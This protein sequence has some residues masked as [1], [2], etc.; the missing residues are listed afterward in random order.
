MVSAVCT[1]NVSESSVLTCYVKVTS[2][3]VPL[4]VILGT[5]VDV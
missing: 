5:V 2:T 1:G 3:S 4:G